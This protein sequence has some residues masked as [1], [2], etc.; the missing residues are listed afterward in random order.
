MIERENID[1]V[2]SKCVELICKKF[3]VP[4][5]LRITDL[6]R[7]RLYYDRTTVFLD[8]HTTCHFSIAD[9]EVLSNLAE[10]GIRSKKDY[11]KLHSL[12]RMRLI[13]A[14][15]QIRSLTEESLRNIGV[16]VWEN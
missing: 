8:V 16:R 11:R 5:N 3:N 9:K 14:I 6:F 1:D 7:D 13:D 10:H 15:Y 12:I 4:A 2:I